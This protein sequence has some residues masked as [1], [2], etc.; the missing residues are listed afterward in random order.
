VTDFIV[1]IFLLAVRLK[2][3]LG[4]RADLPNTED[5]TVYVRLNLTIQSQIVIYQFLELLLL[6]C[7][8]NEN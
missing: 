4:C 3:C 6:I 5:N 7:W 2:F 1:L 8:T